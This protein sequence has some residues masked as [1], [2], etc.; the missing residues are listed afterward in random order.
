[1]DDIRQKFFLDSF[2]RPTTSNLNVC[3]KNTWRILPKKYAIF[4]VFFLFCAILVGLI[5]CLLIIVYRNTTM[6]SFHSSISCRPNPNERYLIKSI[7]NEY[8]IGLDTLVK[9]HKQ[10]TIVFNDESSPLCNQQWHFIPISN[11]KQEQIFRIQSAYHRN[12]FMISNETYLDLS[13]IEREQI[14]TSNVNY[15]FRLSYNPDTRSC[16]IQSVQTEKIFDSES[17]Q[18]VNRTDFNLNRSQTQWKL[19]S[20]GQSNSFLRK[21]LMSFI[22][23]TIQFIQLP[24]DRFSQW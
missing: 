22:F 15:Q 19:I 4:S 8:L 3:E 21:L 2:E 20:F 17:E 12:L 5:T 11:A 14:L 9:K 23:R 7:A 6:N 16:Q 1:L 24:I 13:Q 18:F 10:K